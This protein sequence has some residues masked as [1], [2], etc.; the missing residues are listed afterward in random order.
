MPEALNI[1]PR[2]GFSATGRPGG[3]F[4]VTSQIFTLTNVGAAPLDWTLA[5]TSPWLSDSPSGGTL[6][7]GGPATS[8]TASLNS[9][10]Y[11]LPAGVYAANIRFINLNDVVVQ[12]RQ[13]TLTVINPPAITAQPTNQ[14]VFWGATAT[15]MVAASGG[16]PL[17]YHWQANG[18][19]LTDGGNVAGSATSTLTLDNVSLADVGT[20]SVIV[21]NA[22]G[23]ISSSNAFLKVISSS[24]II[25]V[26]PT[27][28]T[29]MLGSQASFAVGAAGNQPLFYRW[30]SNGTNLTDGGNLSGSATTSLTVSNV[31]SADMGTYSVVVSNALG[32]VTS[33]GAVLAV[34]VAESGMQLVQNAGFETGSFSSWSQSG[35]FANCSVSSSSPYVHSGSYGALLG[36]V[37]SLGYLSQSLPTV[38]GQVYLL[39]LWLDSPDGLGPNEFQVAWNGTVMFDQTNLGAIGWTNLQFMVTATGTNTVLQLAFQDDQS[40]L[41]LDDIQV[42][43]LVSADGPPIIAT[44][45]AN[46]VALPGGA[47][48]FSVLSAGRLPLFYQWQFDGTNLVNATNATL[49]L[50]NLTSSQMGVYDVLVSNSLGSATSSNALLT[51]LLATPALITFDDLTGSGLVPVG[52]NSLTWSNFYYLDGLTYGGQNGYTAGVVSSPNVAYNAYGAPAAINSSAPFNL[53]SAYLTAALG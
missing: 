52:Y 34:V 36:P 33:T 23:A 14:E 8:V 35:N 39:S 44:Q 32:S 49:A 12:S 30:Q 15:F 40:F 45:P 50:T 4:D 46:Q 11:N 41:G 28:Q 47:A 37:G 22:V 43:P 5:N 53:V 2:T 29:A 24:P 13:F 19:N 3:P 25:T 18:I 7:P 51:V 10:A 20:Y 21:S 26:Q 9:A 31:S 1:T 27:N 38:A 42:S 6:T 16:L 48:K 17:F